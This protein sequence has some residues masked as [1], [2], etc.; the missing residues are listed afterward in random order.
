MIRPMPS[1]ETEAAAIFL[2][3][4]VPVALVR[5]IRLVAA[6]RNE[7]GIN[8]VIVEALEAYTTD[9]KPSTRRKR[10]SV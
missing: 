8:R 10:L 3:V 7:R 9:G 2:R 1:I 5:R 6:D 4:R